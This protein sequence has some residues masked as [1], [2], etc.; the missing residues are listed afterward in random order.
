MNRQ[1]L[2]EA[3]L[4]ARQAE[5]RRLYE[6]RARKELDASV[7]RRAA[8]DLRVAL[9]GRLRSV[10]AD[11]D[12]RRKRDEAM[13]REMD[14]E[15]KG[16]EAARAQADGARA[17]GNAGGDRSTRARQAAVAQL[18]AMDRP[19]CPPPPV[20]TPPPAP[21]VNATWIAGRYDWNGI[22]WAWASGHYERPPEGG[23]GVGSAGADRRQRRRWWCRPGRWARI[24]IGPPGTETNSPLPV[25]G[26]EGPG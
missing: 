8:M 19:S 18:G 2:E 11:P 26:R 4:A 22:A 16:L 6:A 1:R 9:V 3:R 20:E 15:V 17:L 10:G 12:F 24:E 14:A 23:H 21:F 13:F 25:G 5:Q 7:A